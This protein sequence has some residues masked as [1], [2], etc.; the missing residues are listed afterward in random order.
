MHIAPVAQ[1]LP[2][3]AQFSLPPVSQNLRFAVTQRRYLD[4]R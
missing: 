3:Q 1:S 4:E 2:V